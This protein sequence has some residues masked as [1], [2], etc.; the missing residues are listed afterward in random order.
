MFDMVWATAFGWMSYINIYNK[1]STYCSDLVQQSSHVFLQKP[2][3][4]D[5]YLMASTAICIY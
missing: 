4:F 3:R 1:L 2:D 5:A